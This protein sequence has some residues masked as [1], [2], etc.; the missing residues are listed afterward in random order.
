M[1]AAIIAVGSELLGTDRLDTNSL[2]LTE[3]LARYGVELVR[4]AVVGDSIE[5]IAA[6]L[7][8][9]LS[10][11]GLVLVT[12]GLGPTS[13]DV[14]REAVA[15]A[16]GRELVLDPEVL[17][18]IEQRYASFVRKMPAVNRKQ[19]EVF[20]GAEVLPNPRGTAP[21]LRLE[22]G[23]A[24]VFLFPGVPSELL[25]MVAA[26]L[27]PWL[28]ERSGGIGRE[29][30]VIKVACVPES[31]MEERIAPAY[32]DFG[33]EAIT[34]LARPGEVTLLATAEG[35]ESGR[36]A[37]LAAMTARLVE[38][39]GEAVF[40]RGADETLE[41]VVGELLRRAGAT[42]A[43]AESCTGG[44]LSERVTR[45]PGSSDYFVGG[46]VTYTNGLKTRL[47]GVSEE[48]LAAEGAV[49]EPVARAMAE[50]ARQALGADWGIGITGVAG[51]GG[52]SDA[53]PVGTVHLA[54]AGPGGTVH[55]RVRFPGSRETI[56]WQAT[57]LALETLRRLLLAEAAP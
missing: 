10:R 40:A 25:G 31:T 14:T 29:T 38:L 52:G 54:V 3:Q 35:E 16:T 15:E 51:P 42:L 33:R 43:A 6:E 44:L 13:D 23:G 34:I 57:Q 1:R 37:R 7:R 39:A 47:L 24:T 21:G 46:A 28:A 22:H 45:I 32:E 26:N 49:S 2:A 50:G 56:R 18:A 20:A 27:V 11:C 41:G 8:S 30:A 9:A 55:H 48:L 36:R 17:A 4:K 19:A 5:E 12:G 53:K